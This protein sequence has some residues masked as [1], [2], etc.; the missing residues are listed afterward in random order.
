MQRISKLPKKVETEGELDI[1]FGDRVAEV[2]KHIA[3]WRCRE[4]KVDQLHHWP[5]ASNLTD[6]TTKGRGVAQDV[7]AGG[8]W[9]DGPPAGWASCRM[10]LRQD[11]PP[12]G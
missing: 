1:W 3:S 12:A 10:V 9:Q 4:I 5:G 7:Q 2:H 8:V 6:I 11:G